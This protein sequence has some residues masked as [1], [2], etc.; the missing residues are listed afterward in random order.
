[1]NRSLTE[2][3]SSAVVLIPVA[4][5]IG[6]AQRSPSPDNSSAEAVIAEI[7]SI[8]GGLKSAKGVAWI[9]AES[10][11]A[12]GRFP[13]NV[14]AENG[15]HLTLEVTNLLGGREALIQIDS[16]GMSI[17][18]PKLKSRSAQTWGGIPL[19]FASVL[20][21]G[22]I[23]C[24]APQS[25]SGAQVTR[26]A[27]DRIRIESREEAFEFQLRTHAGR[28]WP[29]ALSWESKASGSARVSFVFSDPEEYSRS[30]KKWE[31]TSP[32]GSVQVSWRERQTDPA[33]NL[34]R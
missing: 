8:G 24:P 28:P 19:R 10:K 21:L 31:A 6:C 17:D 5:S 7:C 26:S 1:M 16:S 9:K 13:S 18:S 22:R 14:L 2:W 15:N 3:L 29:Q 30:P 12:R 11:E 34:L 23:P 27:A 20:F 33:L 4:W 25:M 32:G